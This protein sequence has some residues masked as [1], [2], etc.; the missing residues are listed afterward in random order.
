[1]DG[2]EES[3]NCIEKRSEDTTHLESAVRRAVAPFTQERV[4]LCDGE[5]IPKFLDSH[6]PAEALALRAPDWELVS[7]KGW[8][9]VCEDSSAAVSGENSWR[10]NCDK[11]R[12]FQL[13]LSLKCLDGQNRWY[14]IYAAPFE[15]ASAAYQWCGTC[16]LVDDERKLLVALEHARRVKS[17]FVANVSH[18]LRTPL[19]GILGMIELL[20]RGPLSEEASEHVL[21]MQEAGRSLLSIV[22][23]V[24][25]FSKIEDGKLV[26][27]KR[28]CDIVSVVEAVTQILTPAAAAKNILLVSSVSQLESQSFRTDPQRLRQILLNLAGNAVKFTLSGHIVLKVESCRLKDSDL[29]WLRFSVCDTGIGIN[30]DQIEKL[31]EPFAQSAAIGVRDK[32]GTGL[33]L[34]ISKRLAE[35][36]GGVIEVQSVPDLGSTFSLLLPLEDELAETALSDI[37]SKPSRPVSRPVRLL[38]LEP[39]VNNVAVLSDVFESFDLLA[40]SAS[41]AEAAIRIINQAEQDGRPFHAVVLDFVRNEKECQSMLQYLQYTGLSKVLKTVA[42]YG[43]EADAASTEC[44]YSLFMPLLRSHILELISHIAPDFGKGEVLS[45]AAQN[46]R[47]TSRIAVSEPGAVGAK[48]PVVSVGDRRALV[49]DDHA[50]NQ[51]VLNLF[52]SDLGF[53]VDVT[54]DGVEAVHAFKEKGYSI[55]FLDCQMPRLNGFEAAKIIREIQARRGVS[56]PVIAVTANAMDGARE[57]CLL[58]GMDDYLSKPVDPAAL[59]KLVEHWLGPVTRRVTPG[60][61]VPCITARALMQSQGLVDFAYLRRSFEPSLLPMICELFD[62]DFCAQLDQMKL[63]LA[64][65]DLNGLEA[66]LDTMVS[67]YEL[68]KAQRLVDLSRSLQEAFRLRRL[69]K[70][71]DDLDLLIRLTDKLVSDLEYEFTDKSTVTLPTLG[72]NSRTM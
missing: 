2:I 44:T 4:F 31:F 72:P 56:V 51:K 38:C 10:T 52:L 61:P 17:E 60:R 5:G 47:L 33:G 64:A 12:P 19:N 27:E 3:D 29:D 24:L 8:M 23:E 58:G 66:K 15:E 18:E 30:P 20:L 40:Q 34:T 37:W 46:P 13:E 41:S 43:C 48:V 57:E 21:M 65:G 6:F 53:E 54:V 28:D 36:L 50:I 25:D 35:L 59:E 26:V 49:A 42:V 55:V 11:G 69:E 22:N 70:A 68:I 63:L 16:R 32:S 39:I 9:A 45:R 62:R 67:A 7:E 1:M 71:C 14:R